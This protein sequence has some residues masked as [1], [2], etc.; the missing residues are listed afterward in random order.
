MQKEKLYLFPEYYW[1]RLTT[2]L[3]LNFYNFPLNCVTM[4]INKPQCQP[5]K[6]VDIYDDVLL[7]FGA[8]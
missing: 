5:F 2:H 7:G 4:I 3:S 6:E 1:Y 8:V